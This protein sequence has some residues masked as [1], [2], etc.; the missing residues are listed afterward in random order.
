MRRSSTTVSLVAKLLLI[1][2]AIGILALRV[3]PAFAGGSPQGCSNPPISVK[4]RP[5]TNSMYT[6]ETVTITATCSDMDQSE[7]CALANDTV[8]KLTWYIDGTEYVDGRDQSAVTLSFSTTGLKHIRLN[9]DDLYNL[10]DDPP[11]NGYVDIEVSAMPNPPI[12]AAAGARVSVNDPWQSDGIDVGVNWQVHFSGACPEFPSED[13]DPPSGVGS[14]CSFVDDTISSYVWDFG[15]TTATES[16]AEVSHTYTAAGSYV[17]KLTVD[18]AGSPADDPQ[19]EEPASLL[20]RVFAAAPAAPTVAEPASGVARAGLIPI[21][22]WDGETH[23]QY[24]VKVG[25]VDDPEVTASWESGT[26]TGEESEIVCGVALAESTTYYVFVREHNVLGWGPWSA[27]GY[28]FTVLDDTSPPENIS[29]APNAGLVAIGAATPFAAVYRDAHCGYGQI[30]ITELL[31]DDSTLDAVSAC[32]LNYDQ[33]QNTC[34]LLSDDASEWL[35]GEGYTPGSTDPEKN[36]LENS[37]VKVYLQN[38][39]VSNNGTTDLTVTWSIEFKAAAAG[40]KTV[41]LSVVTKSGVADEDNPQVFG[42]ID[43]GESTGPVS[44]ITSPANG[45]FV[46]AVPS[47]ISG[48][49][50]DPVY[51]IDKVEVSVD[52]GA[53]WRLAT[54]GSPGNW[55]TWSYSWQDA[56]DG[57][58]TIISR[59]TNGANP[60]E[61]ETP[62]SGVNVVVDTKAPRSQIYSPIDGAQLTGCEIVVDGSAVDESNRISKVELSFDDGVT[63]HDAN[64]TN[65]FA[66]SHSVSAN[67]SFVIKSRAY[68]EAGHIETPNSSVTVSVIYE[69][70]VGPQSPPSAPSLEAPISNPR[71]PDAQASMGFGPFTSLNLSSMSMGTIVPIVQWTSMGNLS[72]DLSLIYSSAKAFWANSYDIR[73][74]IDQSGEEIKVDVKYPNGAKKLFIRKN[75]QEP[76]KT[77]GDSLYDGETDTCVKSETE[78]AYII[79]NRE[80]I[81][82]YFKH[83]K[84][85]GYRLAYIEEEATGKRIT[86]RYAGSKSWRVTRITDPDGKRELHLYYKHFSSG[87]ILLN[88]VQSPSPY[89]T[90]NLTRILY[91]DELKVRK[92]Q[93]PHPNQRLQGEAQDTTS[94]SAY[95]NN[96]PPYTSE[97]SDQFYNYTQSTVEFDYRDESGYKRQYQRIKKI[98]LNSGSPDHTTDIW[99]YDYKL[100]VDEYYSTLP[101]FYS[102]EVVSTSTILID[103]SG[104]KTTAKQEKTYKDFGSCGY[105]RKTLV[106]DPR[107]K[108]TIYW[109]AQWKNCVS[110]GSIRN[111]WG[112]LPWHGFRIGTIRHR[113]TANGRTI[114]YDERFNWT[115]K[116]KDESISTIGYWGRLD[117]QQDA[118][119]V[120]TKYTWDDRGRLKKME[121]LALHETSQLN[122]NTDD[123][124][125][126]VQQPANTASPDRKVS[127]LYNSERQLTK[128][129]VDPG[130]IDVITDFDYD[131]YGNLDKSAGPYYSAD[132]SGNAPVVESVFDSKYHAYPVT[133][134]DPMG[135]VSTSTYGPLGHQ[136]SQTLPSLDSTVRPAKL[137]WDYDKVGRAYYAWTAAHPRSLATVTEFWPGGKVKKTTDPDGYV[138]EYEYDHFGNVLLQKRQE[139]HNATPDRIHTNYTYDYVGRLKK[140]EVSRNGVNKKTVVEYV[141][142]N[143]GRLIQTKSPASADFP[144][145]TSAYIE[146]DAN[147]NVKKTTDPRGQVITYEYDKANR[148][149][150][151]E[152]VGQSKYIKRVYNSRGELTQVKSGPNKNNLYP[153]FQYTYDTAGRLAD[154]R[155]YDLDRRSHYEYTASGQKKR[156][157]IKEL[158]SGT[159]LRDYYY[160]YYRDDKLYNVV[161]AIGSGATMFYYDD[162]GRPSKTTYPNGAY[163]LYAYWDTDLTTL[164]YMDARSLGKSVNHY[165]VSESLIDSWSYNSYDALGN[166]L[167]IQNGGNTVN[168]TYDGLSQLLSEQRTG[169]VPYSYWYDY[170][171]NGNRLT[172]DKGSGNSVSYVYDDDNRLTT[173]TESPSSVVTAYHYDASG[174]LASKAVGTATTGYTFDYRGNL[175]QVALPSKT[176]GFDYD[177]LANRIK[178]T[179]NG[180]TTK[181][182]VEIGGNLFQELDASGNASINYNP[183]ISQT[184]EGGSPSYFHSDRLGSTSVFSNSSGYV[185]TDKFVYDAFGNAVSRSGSTPTPFQYVGK[186]GY[187]SDADTDLMLLGVRYYDPLIGR[188]ISKDPAGDGTNWYVYAENNP[189]GAVDPTG[190]YVPEETPYGSIGPDNWQYARSTPPINGGWDGRGWFRAP[191]RGM[192]PV[193]RGARAAQGAKAAPKSQPSV[194]SGKA[195][196]GSSGVKERQAVEASPAVKA[197]TSDRGMFNAKTAAAVRRGQEAHKEYSA[198]AKA[199]GSTVGKAMPGARL[200]PDAIDYNNKIIYE[201]K[202]DTATG[203]KAMGFAEEKYM[204]ALENFYGPEHGWIFKKLWYKP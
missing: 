157:Q 180:Q 134:T 4:L 27:L 63:W 96:D 144:S 125:E 185:T 163:T 1:L 70:C 67:G 108:Q 85:D 61:A 42:T 100:E 53:T 7:T 129:T 168:Y 154:E 11:A 117:W 133:T 190:M 80:H 73:L 56:E 9:A 24:E 194:A 150:D 156:I 90:W 119:G 171:P 23:D 18:D 151:T 32:R 186:E 48:T 192:T 176:V 174:N 143:L 193:G 128:A 111:E 188:F 13:Q 93:F 77:R 44:R 102:S 114:D 183:G 46:S 131:E 30:G 54:P 69:P 14:G 35:G 33:T 40:V 89:G 196:A 37:Q 164:P 187:Y 98:M 199:Q 76:F 38:T 34:S 43:V 91:N 148:L 140:V 141:Y 184:P 116:F 109:H 159:T 83:C 82:Y 88:A 182:F 146:Y 52:S 173:A 153:K 123:T 105:I 71:L 84:S 195:A 64:G 22:R 110:T 160:N 167:Q 75:V 87:H 139:N 181:K 51:G 99:R 92:V 26:V 94:I 8:N 103:P 112:L 45:S 3:S 200:F 127:Y 132:G 6:C 17:V 172:W 161:E 5:S 124:V 21:I 20:V 39:S 10:L 65:V 66:Y 15:D 142:D 170:D 104:R 72:V 60:Q 118:K 169:T 47:T 12:Q 155:F 136:L 137:M 130:R 106:K 135:R 55:S 179:D 126:S 177:D 197:G 201:L 50:S 78:N 74:N 79:E 68:D 202:P 16:G 95:T 57:E 41:A 203:L 59:A 152:F 189:V 198:V 97:A 191:S 175:T 2:S 29:V 165:N 158:T 86:F 122:Y 145:G 28:A 25:T 62:G 115:G 166:A 138:T 49:A 101:P 162:R 121:N 31:I 178:R 120:R 19:P 113:N 149:T 204:G 81:K 36:V 107:G 58:Y 147:D